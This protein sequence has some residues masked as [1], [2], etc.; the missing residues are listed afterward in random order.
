MLFNL[1]QTCTDLSEAE[2]SFYCHPRLVQSKATF[3]K[4]LV[5][6]S[7]GS[8]KEAAL[9]QTFTP[10]F[11]CLWFIAIQFFVAIHLFE[12]FPAQWPILHSPPVLQFALSITLLSMLPH[13]L[14]LASLHL[15]GS[16][17]RIRRLLVSS[18]TGFFSFTD[19]LETE[20]QHISEKAYFVLDSHIPYVEG[21]LLE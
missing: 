11:D 7:S 20:L 1:A 12:C 16:H 9:H 5:C 4:L 10:R 21:P 8:F 18:F 14:I 15:A 6:F 2:C 13:T 3:K 19:G 17:C